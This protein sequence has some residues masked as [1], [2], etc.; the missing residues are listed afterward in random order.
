VSRDGIGPGLT[1]VIYTVHFGQHLR[2]I[3]HESSRKDARCWFHYSTLL[4]DCNSGGGAGQ[5]RWYL[6]KRAEV[7]RFLIAAFSGGL[8]HKAPSGINKT[9]QALLEVPGTLSPLAEKNGCQA[10]FKNSASSQRRPPG[11]WAG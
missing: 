8:S 3:H 2:L 9:C 11:L 4:V 5:I 1:P 10:G 6:G 7:I